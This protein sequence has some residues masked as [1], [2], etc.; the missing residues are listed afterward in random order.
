MVFKF[1]CIFVAEKNKTIGAYTEGSSVLIWFLRHSK[2]LFVSWHSL[3]N[4][5]KSL[6]IHDNLQM[7][8][9]ACTCV[10]YGTYKNVKLAQYCT[11]TVPVLHCGGIL[12]LF[13]RNVCRGS[14][15]RLFYFYWNFLT[16]AHFGPRTSDLWNRRNICKNDTLL[17]CSWFFSTP[18]PPPPATVPT[19]FS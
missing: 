2:K 5:F 16:N 18:P 1:L 6:M 17:G 7:L 4:P 10:L 14:V 9:S 13:F 12:V 15:H 19:Q 3:A 8:K 11:G